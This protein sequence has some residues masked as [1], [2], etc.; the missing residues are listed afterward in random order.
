MI[1]IAMLPGY[2]AVYDFTVIAY[3]KAKYQYLDCIV[4]AFCRNIAFK[5]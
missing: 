2:P 3:N 4:S 1:I 5:L